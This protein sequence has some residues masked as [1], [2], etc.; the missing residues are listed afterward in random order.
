MRKWLILALLFGFIF[1]HSRAG[2]QGGIKLE[3]MSID[4]WPEYDRS[5]MLV[6][7]QFVVSRETSLPATVT[8]RFPTKGN[9]VAVAVES[10]GGLFNKDFSGPAQQGDWQA[11]T[12]NVDSYEPHRIEYYQP[13]S[14]DGT[15]R[16]FQYQWFGDYYVEEFA[17]SILVPA[18]STQLTT[19]PV[20]QNTTT[21]EDG[22]AIS[23]TV[24]KSDLK[25]GNSFRFELEYERTSDT[26]T[27]PSESNQ[28]QPSEP[29]NENTPGRVSIANLPLIIGAFGLGLIGIAL[30]SYWR[31]TQTSESKPRKRRRTAPGNAGEQAYCHDCG[32]RANPGDRFCRTCGSRLRTD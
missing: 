23:G 11:I 10:N 7:K 17:V 31:S 32:T 16:Q 18:D 27:D 1:S 24:T 19:Y 28:F 26:L 21:T 2:A 4:L 13:L 22:T 15:R 3:L 8:L 20:L 12:I 9:L 30:F 6:I 14:R 5:S 25:M 29:V